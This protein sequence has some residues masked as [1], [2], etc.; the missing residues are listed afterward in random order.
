[1]VDSF[2]LRNLALPT[3]PA[4]KVRGEFRHSVGS[5]GKVVFFGNGHTA[6]FELPPCHAQS[7]FLILTTQS[8]AR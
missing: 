2:G 5:D 8:L 3:I 6:V 7:S 1:M 4:V